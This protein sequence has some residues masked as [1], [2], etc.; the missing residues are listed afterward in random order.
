MSVEEA[1]FVQFPHP[2]GEHRP[3]GDL[4]PWN[5]GEHRR[6][7]LVS[8]GRYVDVDPRLR[9]AE[10]VFW[11]EWEPPSRVEERWASTGH[12]P[13]FLHRPYWEH[14]AKNQARQNTDPWIFGDQMLY[15]NCKQVTGPN[16]NPTSM[17]RLRRGSVIC[18]GSTI[19]GEFCIDTVFVVGSREPWS[20]GRELSNV[21][22][23]FAT[24]TADSVASVASDRDAEFTLYRGAM[25]SDS[26]HGMYCF[27]PAKLSGDRNPR[28]AR[29]AVRSRFINPANKQ[30]TMGSKVDLPM[31]TVYDAWNALREQVVA[32]GLLIAVGIDTPKMI[33]DLSEVK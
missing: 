3:I 29:P 10:L 26:V 28:F 22:E 8:W 1:S 25:R 5:T 15:S 4:M 31:Q 27:V 14:P 2:G 24:C 9:L 21:D 30:S 13:S 19:Q 11:G 18:F 33:A 32:Q 23:A 20:P 7:F 16:R 6:K 17:Q 12:L